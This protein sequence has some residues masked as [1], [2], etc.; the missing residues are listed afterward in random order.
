LW[1]G[2]PGRTRPPEPLRAYS[3]TFVRRTT[4]KSSESRPGPALPNEPTVLKHSFKVIVLGA[5]SATVAFGLAYRLEGGRSFGPRF[6]VGLRAATAVAAVIAGL[7]TWARLELSRREHH[8]TA[9]AELTER[10]GRSV[11]QLGNTD[12]VIRVGG[13][14]AMERFALDAAARAGEQRD[15]DWRMALDVLAAFAR[16]HSNP[17][18]SSD[19]GAPAT[20]ELNDEMREQVTKRSQSPVDVTE[21]VRVLGRFTTRCELHLDVGYDLHGVDLAYANLEGSNLSNANLEGANLEGINLRDSKLT[22]A[23]LSHAR[24]DGGARL[25]SAN[26]IGTNL[27]NANLDRVSLRTARLDEANLWGANL[28]RADLLGA[29][30]EDACMHRANLESANLNRTILD[31]VDLSGAVLQNADLTGAKLRGATLVEADLSGAI[32]N[33]ADLDGTRLNRVIHDASTTWPA[34]AALP[35]IS[36]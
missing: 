12:P 29:S 30:F 10:F 17:P 18:D 15:V 31:R 19:P 26:L 33:D 22:G 24:L 2:S 11:E 23:N 35:Q 16:E 4:S 20:A 27:E 25:S 32:L 8:L 14:L 7:L 36:N 34:K 21:A 6:E 28:E 5:V 13:I 1:N 9:D 3:L